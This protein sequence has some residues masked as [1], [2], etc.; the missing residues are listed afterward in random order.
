MYRF[1]VNVNIY[2]HSYICIDLYVYLYLYMIY[3]YIYICSYLPAWPFFR[4]RISRGDK[5]ASSECIE[6]RR[7]RSAPCK[8]KHHDEYDKFTYSFWE[9]Y[10]RNPESAV[11]FP[12]ESIYRCCGVYTYVGADT[13]KAQHSKEPSAF[14]PLALLGS[15]WGLFS[16]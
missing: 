15:Q 2:I 10:R 16:Y 6:F 9:R 3:L 8:S 11:N 7:N 12:E 13:W 5:H 14:K 4:L 1:H